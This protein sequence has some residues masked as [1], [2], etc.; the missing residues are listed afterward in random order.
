M[1][2]FVSA[3]MP[4]RKFVTERRMIQE[5]EGQKRQ[6]EPEFLTWYMLLI[7]EEMQ[8]QLNDNNC[9]GATGYLSDDDIFI[10]SPFGYNAI[11]DRDQ[12][13]DNCLLLKET[14]LTVDFGIGDVA[15]E[16]VF[17]FLVYQFDGVSVDRVNNELVTTQLRGIGIAG[18]TNYYDIAFLATFMEIGQQT[19]FS[20]V[21]QFVYNTFD[22][23]RR[24]ECDR[25]G[26]SFIREA[27]FE[28]DYDTSIEGRENIT[29]LC[30]SFIAG[31][32]RFTIEVEEIFVSGTGAMA[33]F[34]MMGVEKVTGS[35][36]ITNTFAF[37][38][39]GSNT[40]T[41]YLY[42]INDAYVGTN[43]TLAR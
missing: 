22:L 37:F 43:K 6:W 20:T 41:E 7:L 32:S 16:E 30:T 8:Q 25:W 38:E 39:I 42:F 1:I 23:L 33:Y 11:W 36:F 17:G 10:S 34:H 19:N 2:A 14:R 12:F 28:S 15:A 40:R 5:V 29:A 3:S 13:K 31:F 24:G 9:T 26:A 27:I 4:L 21:R 18:F 35:P